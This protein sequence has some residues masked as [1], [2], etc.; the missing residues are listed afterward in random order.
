MNVFIIHGA[1]GYPEENWF[2]WL[3]IEL[4]QLG[5]NCYVPQFPTPQNQSLAN[6]MQL[7]NQSYQHLTTP[8]SILIGH[9]L[10]AVFCLR[11]LEEQDCLLRAVVLAGV[12][13]DYLGIE[14]FD[15]INSSFLAEDFN[16]KHIAKRS[17][18]FACFHG[19][20]DPYVPKQHVE[21]VVNQLGAK[22]IIISQGGHLNTA[23]NFSQFPHLL[24]YLKNLL[25]VQA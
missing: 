20:N 10:G 1:Y 18:E 12:F 5:V 25:G 15:S 2:N 4:Y 24:I 19:E 3:K 8:N 16:W 6:W 23:A 11:W 22:K 13:I 9:S 17:Q 14:K 21:Q 7:F